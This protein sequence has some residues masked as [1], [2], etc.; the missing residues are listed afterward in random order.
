MPLVMLRKDWP[1]EF[2]RTVKLSEKRSETLV[3][4]PGKPVDLNAKQIEGVKADLGKCL[5]PVELDSKG[6]IRVITDD[7]VAESS[8]VANAS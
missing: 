6:K 7:V 5:Q 8:N 1:N 4:A 3:F 2:R